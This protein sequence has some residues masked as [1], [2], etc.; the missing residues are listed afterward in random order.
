VLPQL[1][2][3]IREGIRLLQTSIA[4]HDTDGDR[5]NGAWNRVILAEIYLQIVGLHRVPPAHVVLK[6][7]GT[8]VGAKLFGVRRARILLE[9]SGAQ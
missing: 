6:N 9:Q 7:L 8:I 2:C 1:G 4:E 5:P 3:R